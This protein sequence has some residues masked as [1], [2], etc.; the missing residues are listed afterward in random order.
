[1]QGQRSH[2]GRAPPGTIDFSAP[3]NPLGPPGWILDAAR[4]ALEEL[5]SY[6]D[7]EYSELRRALARVSGAQEELIVPLNGAAEAVPLLLAAIRPR[8]LAVFEP[9]FG[10]NKLHAWAAG[11]EYRAIPLRAEDGRYVLDQDYACKLLRSLKEPVLALLS[12]PNNPTGML[13]APATV[14]GLAECTPGIL[15]VDEAFIRLSDRPDWS[16]QQSPPDNAVVVSSLTKDLAIPGV[17]LGYLVAGSPELA[18][19]IDAMRQPWNVNSIAAAVGIAAG[20][21]TVRL[22]SYLEEARRVIAAERSRLAKGLE[23][24]G[25]RVYESHAP[26]ILA[27]HDWLPH[28]QLNAVLHRRGIHVRDASSFHGLGPEYSRISVRLPEE[29]NRLLEAVQSV[30]ARFGGRGQ[31]GV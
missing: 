30:A 14:A 12:N 19:R 2:G 5:G 27:R 1:M 26:Y 16:L 23:E 11:V 28:P 22:Q 31:L 10:D 24:A 9:T 20:R 4:R 8:V 17:R 3:L 7:Y 6:P 15:V 21:D 29:N 25:F 18:R 13:A